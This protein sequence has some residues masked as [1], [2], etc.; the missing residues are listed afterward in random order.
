MVTLNSIAVDDA[1]GDPGNNLEVY[2]LVT[3]AGTTTQT[4]FNK[5]SDNY[6]EINA[7]QQFNAGVQT[8]I[9]VNPQ[10]GQSINLRAHLIDQDTITADDDLGDETLTIPFE[11][12]WRKDATVTLTGSGARVRVNFTLTPI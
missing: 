8:V 3:A 9:S 4:M 2:G 11:T 6:V 10:P 12:G 1:G 7:G 5:N